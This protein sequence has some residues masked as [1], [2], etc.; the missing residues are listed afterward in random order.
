MSKRIA[1]LLFAA[2][3]LCALDASAFGGNLA[4]RDEVVPGK[5]NQSLP[6]AL[7][8]VGIDEH[9]GAM[10]PLETTFKDETGKDV[11]LSSY[12]Q[13]GKPVLMNFAYYRCPMLCNMVLNG[14][15]EG[16]RKM[17][18][19]PGQEF[20]VV[21]VG[22]DHREGP[23]LAKAKKD[24][25]IEALK[26]PDAAAGWHFLTGDQ[27][28]IKKVADAVGFKFAYN[29]VSDE[30]A[31]QAAVF[32][33]SPQGKISRY[34]YGIE[35]RSKD[36]RLAL[37]DASEGKALSFGDKL[38]MF[39]YRYDANAKGYVLFAR[40]FMKGGGYVVVASL[41]LLL[42]SLWRKEFKRNK[43]KVVEPVSAGSR[44]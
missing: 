1:S 39:C 41:G 18:W 44:A 36:L 28:S 26:K 43:E 3:A 7:L 34:L 11:K 5:D 32:T 30:Y 20:E 25:H 21:T 16:M 14:M 29:K 42:A 27:E 2:L 24:T 40:N 15:V 17:S 4:G 13:S 22:I 35:Y 9:L 23:D 37:L 10:L 12:F 8:D 19:T 31:H 38:V 6:D 33:I